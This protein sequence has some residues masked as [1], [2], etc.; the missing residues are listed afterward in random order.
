MANAI[1]IPVANR[2]EYSDTFCLAAGMLD[3]EEKL[4]TMKCEWMDSEDEF[5]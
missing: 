2:N 4:A 3:K 1:G 5:S